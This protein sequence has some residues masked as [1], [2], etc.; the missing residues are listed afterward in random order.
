M[1]DAISEPAWVQAARCVDTHTIVVVD[2]SGSMRKSDVPGY[3]SRTEAGYHCLEKD[4]LEPQLPI[5]QSIGA[6]KAVVSLIEMGEHANIV[7]ERS[8]VNNEVQEHLREKMKN[9]KSG[10]N[11]GNYIPAL[12]PILELQHRRPMEAVD[13][14][15]FVVFLSDGA[16]SDHIQGLCEHRCN[17]YGAWHDKRFAER[18]RVKSAE[19]C[20]NRKSARTV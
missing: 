1:D 11:Y 13:E 18:G 10:K 17:P 4:L 8:E 14:K 7:L 3:K 5:S 19:N 20:S 16:P 15:I 12:D 2:A 6:G 9:Y